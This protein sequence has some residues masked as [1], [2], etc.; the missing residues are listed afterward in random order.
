MG[1]SSLKIENKTINLMIF[2]RNY[3]K[4][5]KENEVIEK[6]EVKEQS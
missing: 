6:N 1:I 3:K 4:A 5:L 2:K